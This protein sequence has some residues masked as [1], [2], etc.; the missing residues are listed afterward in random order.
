MTVQDPSLD[1]GF[2]EDGFIK[3]PQAWDRKSAT[4]IA[5]RDGIQDL[6][7]DHWRVIEQLRKHYFDT[8]NIPVMR[9]ICREI[10]LNEHCVSDLLHDPMRAWRIAGLPNPGEEA[11]AYLESSDIHRDRGI[12]ELKGR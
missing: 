3:D 9:H 4:A 6:G 7:D 2:D 11:K 12:S 8:G 1:S 10:G 5:E